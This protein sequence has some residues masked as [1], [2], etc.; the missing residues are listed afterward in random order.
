VILSKLLY[1]AFPILGLAFAWLLLAE[2]AFAQKN[3]ASAWPM[4]LPQWQE[5]RVIVKVRPEFRHLCAADALNI[6]T[7]KAA[8]Q[9]L[10]VVRITRTFSN[11][12]IPTGESAAGEP[13]VDL[14]LTYNIDY[15]SGTPVPE[16]A[17]LL[18]QDGHLVYAEPHVYHIPFYSPNDLDTAQQWFAGT[19]KL[20]EGWDISK[21]DTNVTIGIIDTG[22]EWN[23]PDLVGNVQYKRTD[24]IDGFDNDG[25]GYID[26]YR[27]WDL[28]GAHDNAFTP[29]NN[30]NPISNLNFIDHGT[31]VAG[32]AAASTDNNLGVIGSGFKCRFLPIKASADSDSR[33]TALILAGYD[34]VVYAANQG[35]KVINCSWGGLIFTQTG[36]DAVNYATINKNSVVV[37]AG[38]NFIAEQ[39][40][41]PAAFQNVVSVAS[42]NGIGVGETTYDYSIDVGAV[43]K[44][45][46]T[47]RG[48]LYTYEGPFSSFSSPL[49][50]GVLGIIRAHF[51]TLNAQQAAERLRVTTTDYYANNPAMAPY[52]YKYGSGMVNLQKALTV[53]TPAIRLQSYSLTDGNNNLFLI[54]DT[55]KFSGT[56]R[57]FLSPTSNLVVT[58]TTL[59]S[60]DVQLVRNTA[61]LGVINTLA[62]RSNVSLPFLIRI[63]PGSANNKLITLRI[64]YTDGV[65]RDVEHIQFLINPTFVTLNT[66]TVAG[67]F[68]SLGNIGFN[69]YPNNT[70][71]VGFSR[72]GTNSLFS[73]GLMIGQRKKVMDNVR[74][75]SNLLDSNFTVIQ[76]ASLLSPGPQA[77]LEAQGRFSDAGAGSQ[78]L[79]LTIDQTGLAYTD[80][81]N[82]DYLIVR[83]T[84]KNNSTFQTLDSM[85]TGLFMDWDAGANPTQDTARVDKAFRMGYVWGARSSNTKS[86]VGVVLLSPDSLNVFSGR[87]DNFVY[88][89]AEKFRTLR[90]KTDSS[91]LDRTDVFQVVSAGPYILSPGASKDIYFALVN[92]T[93]LNLLKQYANAAK[94][95]YSCLFST[96]PLTVRLGNDT[97]VC[98]ST[99]LNAT[100]ANATSYLWSNNSTN[101][102]LQVTNSGTYSVL[103]T[104][105]NGC[106]AGDAIVVNVQAA[107]TAIITLPDTA[108]TGVPFTFGD[109]T[110]TSTSWLW[111]FGNGFG[112]TVKTGQMFYE[113]PGTFQVVVLVQAGP[114]LDTIRRTIHVLGTTANDPTLD[115]N[116]ISVFPNPS[117]DVL[118]I[119][120]TDL[121]TDVVELYNLTGV[122]VLAEGIEAG[123]KSLAL[124]VSDLPNG[125]YLLRVVGANYATRIV[126]RH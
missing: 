24:P 27:G 117:N 55:I 59:N 30:P 44:S 76:R 47:T 103:L 125:V 119:T 31:K 16:A 46:T 93:S 94:N 18:G 33:G 91:N 85:Y 10:G 122:R 89:D 58:V 41:Y 12:E 15:T 82:D 29:D 97:S 56:F 63:M 51:P 96:N 77:N 50:A 42:V 71:G 23:H 48:G 106:T 87:T 75:T 61:S 95:R 112:S 113:D 105:A 111:D 5:G 88:S 126:V 110:P 102:T 34:G 70:Q 65:Y 45:A 67:T 8:F 123:Q 20:R 39:K 36:Q 81:A 14:T 53:S 109:N 2:P 118:N 25:D 116:R 57:N 73:G 64:T 79:N 99:T 49:A 19:M 107:G 114:C 83:Y 74:N 52:L 69:D 35:C 60:N 11:V 80:P 90:S 9:Q 22:T 54:G 7:L 32:F 78:R 72:L 6:P 121:G 13:L 98:G 62:S 104:D 92:G 115:N 1:R 100:N 108:Y 4:G 37:A 86:Y 21:G 101:P 40:N 68:T 17:K 28:V 26:N 124:K 84:V 43:G 66:G 38:G 120:R 3:I